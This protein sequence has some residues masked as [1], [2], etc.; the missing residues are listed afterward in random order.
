MLTNRQ[1]KNDRKRNQTKRAFTHEGLPI[2]KGMELQFSKEKISLEAMEGPWWRTR[3]GPVDY[4]LGHS[5][6]GAP[7]QSKTLWLVLKKL[8]PR[9]TQ[10]PGA[11]PYLSHRRICGNNRP[12]GQCVLWCS[13][14][15][16]P[17][18]WAGF[19]WAL[20]RPR[21]LHLCSESW[22]TIQKSSFPQNWKRTSWPE[23]AQSACR[24]P[25]QSHF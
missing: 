14:S 11:L 23:R 16:S 21:H 18:E 2:N 12:Q 22:E 25:L 7:T 5:E 3:S 17:C 6:E 10:T 24:L 8:L 15:L 19:L 4:G 13:A 1:T 9:R 20:P